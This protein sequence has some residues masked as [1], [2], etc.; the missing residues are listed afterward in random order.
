MALEQ[1]TRTYTL[2]AWVSPGQHPDVFWQQVRA[3]GQQA[4]LPAAIVAD[5]QPAPGAVAAAADQPEPGA[6]AAAEQPVPGAAADG[7]GEAVAAEPPARVGRQLPQGT[8]YRWVHVRY[9]PA[10]S[11]QSMWV[12]IPSA[13]QVSVGDIKEAVAEAMGTPRSR[14]VSLFASSNS[15]SRNADPNRIYFTDAVV[16]DRLPQRGSTAAKMWATLN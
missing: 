7:A 10:A 1:Q 5:E 12:A 9:A 11:W 13:N 6:A 16:G 4:H 3:Q 8:D 2:P 14:E 15:N